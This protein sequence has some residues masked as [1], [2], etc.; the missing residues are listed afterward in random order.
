MLKSKSTELRQNLRQRAIK[1]VQ[2][3]SWEKT[4]IETLRIFEEVY[5]IN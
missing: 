2:F 4:A 1:R 3:F 5:R